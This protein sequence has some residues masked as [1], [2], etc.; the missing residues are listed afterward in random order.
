MIGYGSYKVIQSQFPAPTLLRLLEPYG[1][2]SPMALLWTLMGAS[3]S[4]NLFTGL[5]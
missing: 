2:S 4:Y 5:N 1:Q 3:K